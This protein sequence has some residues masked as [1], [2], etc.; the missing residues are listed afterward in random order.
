MLDIMRLY[1]R[2][3]WYVWHCEQIC[4]RRK[5]CWMLFLITYMFAA[6]KLY[7]FIWPVT[8][9]ELTGKEVFDSECLQ[10]TDG[11]QYVGTV[12]R[13][14]SGKQCQAWSSQTPQFHTYNDLSYFPDNAASIDDIRNYCRN[15]WLDS[16]DVRPWC[17]P[18]SDIL[19]R[20][21]C[22]IPACKSNKIFYFWNMICV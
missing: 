1:S 9:T 3:F 4:L 2:H 13:T 17:I 5:V 19:F 12:N 10:T 21:Y 15:L 14:I 22:D 8:C 16:Y 6:E 7:M 20:E 11:A 18:M